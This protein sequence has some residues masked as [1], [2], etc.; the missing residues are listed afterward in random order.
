MEFTDEVEWYGNSKERFIERALD[1]E[2]FGMWEGNPELG[3]RLIQEVQE[4]II[5]ISRNL[6]QYQERENGERVA[7]LAKNNYVLIYQKEYFQYNNLS[8]VKLV[9]IDIRKSF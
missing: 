1:R 5:E 6:N 3:K 2:A 8:K 9:I 4:K 7:P